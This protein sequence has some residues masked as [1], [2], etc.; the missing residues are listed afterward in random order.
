MAMKQSD[1][2]L[3]KH[4]LVCKLIITYPDKNIS[5]VCIHRCSS[6]CFAMVAVAGLMTTDTLYFHST[7]SFWVSF[8]DS[9]AIFRAARKLLR[10]KENYYSIGTFKE[11]SFVGNYVSDS[12][13]FGKDYIFSL[14]TYKQIQK[15]AVSMRHRCLPGVRS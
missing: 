4:F 2:L 10:L 13:H 7:M 14:L 15:Y 6:A 5:S 11:K 9:G 1:L 3:Q 8:W 12:L